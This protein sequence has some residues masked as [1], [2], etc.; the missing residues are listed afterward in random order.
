MKS[1]RSIINKLS[2]HE[3]GTFRV[4]LSSH[5]RNGKNKKLELFDQLVKK[6]PESAS[7]DSTQVSRQSV[8]QLKKRLKEEL[9]TFLI[10][11]EQVKVCNDRSFL[12]MECHKKLYC[13]KILFDK[14]IYDHALQM[15]NEVLN[16]ASKHALHSLYLESVN[17]KNIY[18]PMTQTKVVRQIPV[19]HEIKKLK[20]SL[21]RNLYINHYLSESGNFLHESDD[22]FRLRLMRKVSDFDMAESEPV[23]DQLMEVNHLFYQKDFH[24]AHDKLVD[25]L[26]TDADIS[27]DANLVNLV[28]VELTKACICTNALVE[29]QRWLPQ[30]KLSMIKVD[31]FFQLLLELQ[32][33]IAVGSGDTV[34]QKEILEQ[35]RQLREIRE[36]AVL[37]AKWSFFALLISFQERDFKRVIKAANANSTFLFK[38][39]SWLINL[40]M[41]EL[42]SIYQLKD[43][44]WLYYKMES[45]R[46]IISGTEGKQQRI[47]QIANLLKVQISGK[48]LSQSD[49]HDKI[50]RIEKEFPWH[51]LSNELVNYCTYIKAMLAAD[52]HASL[53]QTQSF[54]QNTGPIESQISF[55]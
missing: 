49:T 39:K 27:G 54:C 1:L 45:F 33:I 5:C 40:K 47:S 12:E 44:D 43:S 14:G 17:L 8:Y 34:K 4:F 19:N 41:L 38:D 13:F 36:N 37:T 26:G 23:I 9:Y 16:S 28:Y 10:T 2:H 35:S 24:S 42:L 53:S 29:A 52:S 51:P 31:P 25:L 20:K 46:K 55:Q 6:I 21:G 15:L 18:F 3:I 11:Q 22:S 7:S 50:I 30:A 48:G 32:F